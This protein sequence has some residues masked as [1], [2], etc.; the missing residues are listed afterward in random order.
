MA[1]AKVEGESQDQGSHGYGL[2]PNQINQGRDGP[3]PP[4]CVTTRPV[5]SSRHI[6][7][8]SSG[9]VIKQTMGL[10]LV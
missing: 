9:M 10:R 5:I 6:N 2:E 4:T 3:I 8:T 7:P 1:D